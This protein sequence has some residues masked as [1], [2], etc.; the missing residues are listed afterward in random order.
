MRPEAEGWSPSKR[1]AYELE[2][3]EQTRAHLQTMADYPNRPPSQ[4]EILEVEL[5]G[6]YPETAIHVRY[7]DPCHQK[8]HSQDYRLWRSAVRPGARGSFTTSEGVQ[9]GPYTVGLF[10]CTWVHGG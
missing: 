10:I 5:R 4:Y 2:S 6:E 1:R 3:L 7:L 8:V 9:E